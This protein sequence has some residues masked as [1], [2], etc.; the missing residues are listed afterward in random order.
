MTI[1]RRNV[2]LQGCAIG[3]GVIATQI[4]GVVALAQGQ[5]PQRRSLD[6]SGLAR[7]R[8][9]IEADAGELGDQL[10]ELRPHS[11]ERQRLQPVSARQLV[12]S[13]LAPGISA[14]VR[15]DGAAA[16]WAQRLRA[17]LLGL[18]RR[19]SA[20]SGFHSAN[21]E[22]PTQ[23]AVRIGAGRLPLPKA[24]ASGG[25]VKLNVYLVP[26]KERR[27]LGDRRR[28][29]PL[30]ETQIVNLNHSLVKRGHRGAPA[31]VARTC[32][33]RVELHVLL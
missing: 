7:R 12:L 8:R 32:S 2:L 17:A 19:S 22:W 30:T 4:P 10:G 5:P 23:S 31:Q 20:A 26:F 29:N 24:L 16:D 33:R 13:P 25:A 27:A 21:V 11:R 1:S 14:H 9:A 18:D 3:A 28:R 15:P 6:R